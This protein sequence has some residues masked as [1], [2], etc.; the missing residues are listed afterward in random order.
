MKTRDTERTEHYSDRRLTGEAVRRE[1]KLTNEKGKRRWRRQIYVSSA[2]AAQENARKSRT[3]EQ[4]GQ[5][6]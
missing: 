2:C 5:N 4:K 1:L 6:L 3:T